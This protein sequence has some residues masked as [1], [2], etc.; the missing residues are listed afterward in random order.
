MKPL[1]KKVTSKMTLRE[2]TKLARLDKEFKKLGDD[3][4]KVQSKATQYTRKHKNPTAAQVKRQ[5][6]LDNAGLKAFY[7]F[8]KKGD[9]LNA[10]R[11]KLRGRYK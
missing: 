10:F 7:F 2:K 11:E 1:P 6:V 5:Q 8:N 9:E 4:E 3:M